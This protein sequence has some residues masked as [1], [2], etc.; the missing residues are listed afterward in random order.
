MRRLPIVIALC[1]VVACGDDERDEPTPVEPPPPAA[2][3]QP[4]DPPSPPDADEG[5]SHIGAAVDRGASR[6]ARTSADARSHGREVREQ[7]RAAREATRGGDHAAALPLFE[8]TLRLAPSDERL[9]CETG[10]V[11]F[12]AGEL[13]RAQLLVD[14]ALRRFGSPQEV[15]EA[16]RV[17]LAMCLYN[18]GRVAEAR[19]QPGKAGL[20][21]RTSLSLR[22]NRVVRERLATVGR[23]G[24]ATPAPRATPQPTVEALLAV[25][26]AEVC[27]AAGVDADA[28][29]APCD[30]GVDDEAESER[31]GFAGAALLHVHTGDYGSETTCTS[32]CASRTAGA[33]WAWPSTSSTPACSGSPKRAPQ[34]R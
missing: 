21:Y 23:G 10:Y 13:E 14:K 30:A 24:A 5:G 4:A 18:A 8:A 19:Q 17:P 9:L 27:E 28:A 26:R 3:D 2:P 7:L 15:S 22:D 20:Y 33:T 32:A 29:D 6:A 25:I 12:R 31:E 16:M 1:L 11:A 34:E